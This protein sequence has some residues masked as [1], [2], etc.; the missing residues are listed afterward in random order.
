MRIIITGGT[1][2]IGRAL[3]DFLAPAGHELIVLSRN[4][5]PTPNPNPNPNP[6]PKSPLPNIRVARWDGVSTDGWG[7]L[8]DGADAIVNLAGESIA[9]SGALPSRWT[10]ERKQRILDSRINAT[11]AVVAAIAQARHKPKVLVQGSAI[12]YYGVHGDE[13]LDE[14]APP[15]NDFL[16]E[17][18]QRWEAVSEPV[19]EMGVRRAIARTGLVLSA[20]GGSLP[21]T[22][23]PFRFFMGGPLGS[24][25]QWWSWIHIR[26]EVRALAFLLEDER[27]VGPFNL[28]APNPV[29][30][31]EFARTLGK[32]MGRPAFL[33][34]PAFILRLALGELSTL[35]LDGQRVIPKRLL[36]L[37]F[38]FEFPQ[39]ETA[40]QDLLSNLQK[41]H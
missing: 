35:L 19:E 14:S 10:Q 41:V 29:T 11:N 21:P 17:V 5:N 22:M 7:E 15:G 38:Q 30:N 1:G 26:D 37:G 16:A 27:A 32:V 12:G 34:T 40:L 8:V 23:L 9:G 31:K 39:L 24:G 36:E 28:T 25:R 20:D 18:V 33:P 2:L 13:E 6:N 4:P 3:L